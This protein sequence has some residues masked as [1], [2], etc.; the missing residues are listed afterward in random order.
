LKKIDL[1][2]DPKKMVQSR[3]GGH[4]QESKSLARN[5]KENIVGRKKRLETTRPQ[6][7]I[8]RRQRRKTKND[9]R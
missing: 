1:W 3:I 4:Q 6:N 9:N 5:Q 2:H 7:G 8:K